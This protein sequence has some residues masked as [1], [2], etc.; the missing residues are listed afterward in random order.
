MPA[1]YEKIAT[2]TLGS[3]TATITFDSIAASWTDLRL[4]VVG[5]QTTS[6]ADVKLTFNNDTATNYSSTCIYGTGTAVTS[7]RTTSKA[8]ITSNF[9]NLYSSQ[10]MG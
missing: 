1:T 10:K 4:V 3:A 6:G 7:T 2:T 5:T 9:Y 8:Y